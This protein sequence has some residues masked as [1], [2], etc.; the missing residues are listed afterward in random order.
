MST[1]NIT[2]VILCGRGIQKNECPIIAQGN[3]CAECNFVRY[4]VREP[5]SEAEKNEQE[6]SVEQEDYHV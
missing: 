6:S 3:C 1:K 2:Y 4:V 5:L